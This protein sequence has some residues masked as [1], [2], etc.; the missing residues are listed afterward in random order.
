VKLLVKTL[1]FLLHAPTPPPSLLPTQEALEQYEEVQVTT[2]YKRVNNQPLLVGQYV[3]L[4]VNPLQFMHHALTQVAL[5]F[6]TQVAAVLLLE[7]AAV[8]LLEVTAVLL[9]QIL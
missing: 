5:L 9:S 4:L 3:K 6:Q 8:L 7:V 1:Q 2:E